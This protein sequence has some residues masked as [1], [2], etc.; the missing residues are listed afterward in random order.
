MD[1]TNAFSPLNQFIMQQNSISPTK[2]PLVDEKLLAFVRNA[3][4][5]NQT[6]QGVFPDQQQQ[7]QQ[8]QNQQLQNPHLQQP[9][10]LP[11]LP[12]PQQHQLPTNTQLPVVIPPNESMMNSFSGAADQMLKASPSASSD[13]SSLDSADMAEQMLMARQQQQMQQQLQQHQL[14]QSAFQPVTP[15]QQLHIDSSAANIEAGTPN[16]MEQRS[17]GRHESWF[18]CFTTTRHCEYEALLYSVYVA[19]RNERKY[20]GWTYFD[21]LH[22]LQSKCRY[23]VRAKKQDEFFIVEEKGVHNHGAVE[24][25]GQA[26]SHAGLPKT[27]REIVDKSYNESW[28]LEVRNAKIESEVK[29]LGLPENPRLGRQIDNRVAYLRRVKNLHETRRI[30]DQVNGSMGLIKDSDQ[31]SEALY[32]PAVMQALI[33][34]NGGQL[35][36]GQG[37][38][39]QLFGSQN[40]ADL[41]AGPPSSSGASTSSG[42]SVSPPLQESMEKLTKPLAMN[43]TPEFFQ[44]LQ[45]Q[46]QQMNQMNQMNQVT[47]QQENTPMENMQQ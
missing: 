39:E 8:I 44:L 9:Q 6:L 22:R 47:S 13:M 12:Q 33:N 18:E 43:P 4:Q 38:V 3:L 10:Q 7:A 11:Q 26:G 17:I 21:C 20:D 1:E 23:R 30:Q 28:P 2:N 29:R 14:Q 31:L 35:T 46:Q 41:V 5:N 37:V 16:S 45:Q 19:E 40:I 25:V 42:A 36:V 32:N 27:I 34:K 15:L 24:P